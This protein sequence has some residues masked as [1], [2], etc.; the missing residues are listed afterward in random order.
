VKYKNFT[1]GIKLPS[2]G[3]GFG[4]TDITTIDEDFVSRSID[5]LRAGLDM[6]SNFIDTSEVYGCGESEKIISKALDG[7]VCDVFICTKVSP[8]NLCFSDVINS[9]DN[10]LKRLKRDQIEMAQIHW[11]NPEIEIEQTLDAFIQLKESG[12]IKHFGLSNFG[13]YDVKKINSYDNRL[14]VSAIQLEYNLINRQVEEDIIPYCKDNNI[15]FMGYSPLSKGHMPLEGSEKELLLKNLADKYG[16]TKHQI[17]LKW[18]ISNDSVISIP[19]T[20]D[21]NHLRD[22][23][24]SSDIK[25]E[26]GDIQKINETFILDIREIKPSQINVVNGDRK[27]GEVYKTIQEAIDNKVGYSPSPVELSE[28]I[29]KTGECG[30]V[31]VVPIEDN[32]FALIEGRIKYWAWVIAYG[33]LPI[34]ANVINDLIKD[35]K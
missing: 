24:L 25:L 17:V 27:E 5:C 3:Q 1:E 14:K 12:K 32:R 10:S 31:K 21:I 15:A 13:L 16:V 22:N 7:Q 18:L 19:M 34:T 23:L 28:H 9:I 11:P 29:K 6:G 4:I 35:K 26:S 30:L 2:I 20:G 8:K 33:D